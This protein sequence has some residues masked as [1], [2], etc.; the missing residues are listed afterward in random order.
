MLV[1][2]TTSCNKLQFFENTDFT[3]QNVIL[4]LFLFYFF[5]RNWHWCH[6]FWYALPVPWN[7]IVLWSR[8]SSYRK[9]KYSITLF[10]NFSWPRIW[11]CVLSVCPKTLWQ[12]TDFKKRSDLAEILHTCFLA[13]YLGCFFFKFYNWPFE[14]PVWCSLSTMIVMLA[15]KPLYFYIKRNTSYR[16]AVMNPVK[17]QSLIY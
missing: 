10:L 1:D 4:M 15:F 9:R 3:S 2:S 14:F 17:Y 5:W 7:V 13:K 6:R 11:K 12:P 16:F 8:T